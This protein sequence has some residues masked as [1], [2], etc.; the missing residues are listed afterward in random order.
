MERGRRG[1]HGRRQRQARAQMQRQR[2]LSAGTTCGANGGQSCCGEGRA[3]T[4]IVESGKS[5][6]CGARGRVCG[7]SDRASHAGGRTGMVRHARGPPTAEGVYRRIESRRVA[8]WHKVAGS[9]SGGVA[10]HRAGRLG[11][12]SVALTG[13]HAIACYEDTLVR[14]RGHASRRQKWRRQE[15][16]RQ[17]VGVAR[18]R[19][20]W[21]TYV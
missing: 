1:K 19:A 4:S 5:L 12:G 6:F 11:G 20:G 13:R 10:M 3:L 8:G 16:H 9:R 2:Q 15:W 21:P 17:G 7:R 18:G 14:H